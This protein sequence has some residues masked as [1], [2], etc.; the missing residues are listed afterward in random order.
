LLSAQ[1]KNKNGVSPE[2]PSP[3]QVKVGTKAIMTYEERLAFLKSS[4]LGKLYGVEQ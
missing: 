4:R 2:K 3:Q 1:N